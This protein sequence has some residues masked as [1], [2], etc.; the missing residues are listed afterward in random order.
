MTLEYVYRINQTGKFILPP[1]R[2]EAMYLP[3]QFAELP[4]SD[5]MITKE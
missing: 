3:D 5:Q 4:N 1:T 2:V